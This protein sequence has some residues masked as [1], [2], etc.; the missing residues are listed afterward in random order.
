MTL[1][2]AIRLARRWSRGYVC[3]LRDGEVA[4]Y[5]KLALA[6]LEQEK[7]RREEDKNDRRINN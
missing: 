6:L 2:R 5:H 1:D 4:E 7:Q 3:T